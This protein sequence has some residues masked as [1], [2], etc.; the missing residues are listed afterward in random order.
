MK[1]AHWIWMLLLGVAMLS[2][3]SASSAFA[4]CGGVDGSVPR[5]P[6]DCGDTVN[7]SPTILSATDPVTG[8]VCTAAAGSAALFVDPGVTLNMKS[9]ILRCDNSFGSIIGVWI[10]GN[11]V[12]VDGGS[13]IIDGCDIGVFGGLFGTSN[14]TIQR[15]TA[16]NGGTGISLGGIPPILLSTN[17]TLVRN[18]CDNNAG[19]GIFIL[20]AGNTLDRNY[21]KGNGGNGISVLGRRNDL[22]HNQGRNNDGHGVLVIGGGNI[23]DE[24]NY[25]TGNKT[26]PDCL[27]DGNAPVTTNGKYC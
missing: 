23:T 12:T 27:F 2:I 17:N 15:V 16:R 24:R 9:A 4:F 21:C 26:P 25:A 19:D 18:L 20:G 10:L 14:S 7:I 3:F 8:K 5:V 13:G 1:K 6:C 11:G 22:R